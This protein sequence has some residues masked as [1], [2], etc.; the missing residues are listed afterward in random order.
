M[1]RLPRC[2]HPPVQLGALTE[3]ILFKSQVGFS[4]GFDS[5]TYK[6]AT[7]YASALALLYVCLAEVPACRVSSDRRV[8]AAS[9]R[10]SRSRN[11]SNDIFHL[12]FDPGHFYNRPR[13]PSHCE[14]LLHSSRI[15]GPLSL[16]ISIHNYSDDHLRV[17]KSP[18]ECYEQP[19]PH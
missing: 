4:P 11:F 17:K 12:A 14:L 5:H 6:R 16:S 15:S 9:S 1:P 7:R 18:L 13:L 10:R 19:I 3:S 8:P 2:C